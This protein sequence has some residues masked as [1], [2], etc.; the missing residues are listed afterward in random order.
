LADRERPPV[1]RLRGKAGTALP[2]HDAL[3]HR[4]AF[5]RRVKWRTGCE[6]RIA[7]LKRRSGCDRTL[8]DGLTGARIW[9]GH[10]VFAHTVTKISPGGVT[11]SQEQPG[12]SA[13][14][15]RLCQERCFRPDTPG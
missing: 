8:L 10:G 12:L 9:C 1:R 3:E 6:G 7:H 13:S 2:R 11:T 4:P 15:W 14:G 5:R